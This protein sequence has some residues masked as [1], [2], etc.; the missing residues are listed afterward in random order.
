VLRSI[1]SQA[2][3]TD[4]LSRIPQLYTDLSQA[5]VTD[6]GLG[7]LLK[8][9]LYAPSLT[10]ASIRSY[11]I[12]PPYV[13]SWM[14]PAG[15]SV[16]LPD[17]AALELLMRQATTLSTTAVVRHDT[18]V[19]VQNGTA[20]AGLDGLAANRLNYAGYGTHITP[21]DRQDYG[22]SVVIDMTSEQDANALA[23]L[24]DILGLS[25]ATVTVAPDTNALSDYRVILG[26]DYEA[27]FQPE[28][29]SH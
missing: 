5:I 17:Q 12:R 9:A 26:Y 11:Y 2:L 10:N 23:S 14:T 29:L 27:C 3:R 19:D 28:D 1:F 18:K 25:T 22:A 16:L 8:L 15:A 6:L 21:A 13:S 7:D 24:L 4:T 20:S